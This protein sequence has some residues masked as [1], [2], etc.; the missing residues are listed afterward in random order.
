MKKISVIIPTKNEPYAGTLVKRIN[1]V[2]KTKHE[3]II[4]EKGNRLPKISGAKVFRQKSD[5]LGNAFLEGLEKSSGDVI[6]LTDGDGS[7][8]AE[9]IPKLISKL[10]KADIV[11]GSR[12]VSGGKTFDTAHRQFISFVARKLSSTILGINV[13]DNMSGF[14]A[15]RKFVFKKIKLNPIGYKILLELLYK[16]KR[17]NLKAVEVPII[18]EQRKK[19]KS[20]YGMEENFRLLKLIFSLKLGLR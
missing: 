18:F 15:A 12:F 3:I 17:K 2:L 8:R 14:F 20:K 13:K 4:V 7:H 5:G 19:G 10:N 16:A 6:V 9:D 11:V 1:K